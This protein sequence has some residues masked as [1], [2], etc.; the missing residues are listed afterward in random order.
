MPQPREFDLRPHPRILPMLGEITLLQWR[1]VAELT[2][3][4][5]DAFLTAIRNGASLAAPEVH[6]SLPTSDSPSAKISVRDNGTGMDP[7]TLE[8]A[9]RAG[10]TGNDPVNN[11][12]M[13]GMGFNI[14][15]ARLGT[16]TR[17]WTTRTGDPEWCGLEID[18][19]RLIQQHHF[20]TPE[21]RRPKLD[22]HEHGTEISIEKLKPEQRQWFAK[23]SY[24]SKLTQELGR[25]YSAMLRPNGVPLSFRLFVN[26]NIVKGR[27]HCIWGGEGNQNREVQTTRYGVVNAFQP[28]DIRL[29]DRLFC[30]R[31]W[32]WLPASETSCPGC[33]LRDRTVLRQRR[34]HGWVGLQRYLSSSEY[35]V[36]Y[37]R[38]GR[39]IEIGNRDLFTW[40]DG[41][42]SEEEYPIDDPR[43]RGRIV[44]EIHLDHC[45]VTYT[46]DR[47]D[48]NDPA[49][50]EMVSIVRGQG[51]LRPDKAEQLGFGQNTSPLFLLFQA[52][53]RSSPKPK[54]AGAYA[55]LLVVPDNDRSE[56]MAKRY[57]A[58]EADYQTDVKWMELVEEADRELLVVNTPEAGAAGGLEGW[59]T[60][61]PQAGAALTPPVAGVGGTAAAPAPSYPRTAIASLTREYRDDVTNLRWDVQAFSVQASDPELPSADTAW[62]LKA[63]NAGVFQF[64]VNLEHGIFESAT[65]TALDGLL[66][67]LASAALDFSRAGQSKPLFSQI[68]SR[69]RSRYA[70]PLKLDPVELTSDA[71][72]TLASIARGVGKAL[73]A[74]DAG[75]MFAEF[76]P[77]EQEVILAKMAARAVQSPQS[78]ISQGQFLEYVPGKMLLRFFERHPEFF[79]DGNYWDARYATLDFGIPSAT[80]EAQ[81]GVSRYYGSLIADAIWLAEQ[82]P[83]DLS[84]V[85][86]SRLLRAALA[87]QLLQET[88]DGDNTD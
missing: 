35:G 31:C 65:M 74:E 66:A 79:F 86:R 32:Q 21:L 77:A 36:D 47:F 5:I 7:E 22:R 46:K 43:H 73:G 62:R 18:F 26:G 68:L 82:D 3:N 57:Y 84:E 16:V 13:F 6:V 20:K 63:T 15:T 37:L 38:H 30:Q 49:W 88:S 87:L 50:E 28:I 80:Q 11:L 14:A 42:V 39:K 33:E 51:P 2:D 67:D 17:V 64:L 72:L 12:G 34:V 56:E 1:C 23:A 81:L 9:V 54:V 4:C 75:S 25:V 61:N 19:E 41:Q 44:G 59:P 58:G 70:G 52:F 45:R 60:A 29:A 85:S 53:R 78:V 71:R 40:S 24:R 48:R 55:R 27:N 8:N 83:S 76:S 69:L 10:W